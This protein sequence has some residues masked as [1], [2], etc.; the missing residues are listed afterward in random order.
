M[1]AHFFRHVCLRKTTD[2]FFSSQTSE[3]RIERNNSIKSMSRPEA[4][5][6]W[7]TNASM[8]TFELELGLVD[9]EL[10]H[11]QVVDRI[12]V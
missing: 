4:M 5:G 1:N 10:H 6:T 8:T 3:S 9:L 2:I 11:V 12:R 7:R